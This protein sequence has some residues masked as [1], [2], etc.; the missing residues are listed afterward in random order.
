MKRTALAFIAGA[1]V[2]AFGSNVSGKVELPG[3]KGAGNAVVYL[4]GGAHA[5]P[6]KHATVDQRERTFIPHVSVITVGTT[7]QFPN[8]D[9][10]FHNVFADYD[11]KKFDLGMYPQGRSK[12]MTFDKAGLVVLMCSIHPD[13]GAYLMVVDTPYF[14]TAD[15]KGR[16][17]IANVPPGRYTLKA[18][19]ESGKVDSREV[20][21]SGDQTVNV[22][23]HRG[24]L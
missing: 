21:V 23:L 20:V 18:W 6:L 22:E 2:T 9:T 24:R 8:D 3:G 19:H 5:T 14:A 4:E 17:S 7:V 1:S 16:F 15:K 12:K 10:I 13:M 11:A